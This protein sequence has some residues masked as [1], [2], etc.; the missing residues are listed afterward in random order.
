MAFQ[1]L[2]LLMIGAITALI[3]TIA[4]GLLAAPASQAQSPSASP[5]PISYVASVKANNATNA[6]RFSEYFRNGRL[7]AIGLTVRDLLRLAYPIQSYQLVGAPAWTS[8][9]RYNIEAKVEDDVPP[10]QRE[11]LQ[12]LLKDRFNLAIHNET[13]ELPAFALVLARTDGKLGPHLT[14]SN[15]DCAAY[16]AGPHAPPQPGRTPTCATNI[17]FGALFGKAIPMTQ[18][19]A[20]LAPFVN[21]FTVDET[22]L[23]G[24]FDVELTW[25]PEQLSPNS[26]GNALPD[27]SF[28]SPGSIF[29]ALQEQL[30]LKFVRPVAKMQ[31]FRSTTFST[32]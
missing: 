17:R 6:G 14:K 1:R 20:S 26:E 4:I 27:A 7:V 31:K 9:K 5:K 30:G 15:F 18:L 29:S 12:A 22:G 11:L 8:D 2:N 13:R 21:R 32:A 23:E 28:N 3:A 25:T 16:F 10:S 24:G 19:A